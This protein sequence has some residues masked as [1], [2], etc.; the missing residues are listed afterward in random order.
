MQGIATLAGSLCLVL[1]CRA[2][3]PEIGPPSRGTPALSSWVCQLQ[4]LDEPG[5]VDALVVARADLVVMDPVRTVRGKESFRTAVA[6]RRIRESSGRARAHKLCLAYLNVGQAESYRTYWRSG[7]RAPSPKT[8]G[9]PRFLVSVDPD[10]WE[11]N[12]PVAYWDVRWRAILFGSKDAL[13]DQVI[14]DGFDGVY[15]DW[16]LGYR[17]PAVVAAA[18]EASVDPARAMATLVRDLRLYARRKNEHFIVVAQNGA[19]LPDRV[20]AYYG[21]IDGIAHESVSFGG[22]ASSDWED[23]STGDRPNRADDEL[24]TESLIR[25]LRTFH[26]RGLF[27]LT[28]DYA[29]EPAN[30]A[31]A[32]A[33]SLEAGFVPFVSRTPLDRLP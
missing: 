5:A 30:V 11:G 19:W 10:G 25:Q 8:R 31:R 23:P 26:D 29:R 28:I 14:D 7:W 17:E 4:G 3:P 1:G 13:L 33:R 6:V 24:S 9:D 15:L 27:V 21:W 32:R 20:P 12:Y 22:E 16:I 2:A 18:E